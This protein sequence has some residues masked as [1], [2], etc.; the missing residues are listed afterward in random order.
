MVEILAPAGN[1]NNFIT[2]IDNGADAVYLGLKNFSARMGS[3]NFTIEELK[4]CI[5][6]AKLFGAKV[7][8]AVNTLI[9]DSELNDFISDIENAYLLGAD[10]FILQDIFLGKIIKEKNPDICLHL[11]TQAGVCNEYGA[12]LAK[13]FG[14]SRV[15]L[16]RETKIED[17]RKITKIIETEVFVQ[18][19]LCTSFSG[20]CYFSSIVGGCS[21]NR[22]M[23]KQPCRKLYQYNFG[24]RTESGYMLSLA[25]LCL[26][27]KI[28]LLIDAGV[29]SFKIEGRMRNEDYVGLATKFYKDLVNGEYNEEAFKYLNIAFNR[30]DYTEGLLISQD[31][32]LISK[33]IQS[34][35]G[36]IIGKVKKVYRDNELDVKCDNHYILPGDAFKILRDGYEVGNGVCIGS[37]GSCSY[38]GEARVGD[39]V[40]ITRTEHAISAYEPF[41]KK[42][43]DVKVYIK[44]GEKLR[45]EAEG[46]TIESD[47]IIEEAKSI[48]ISDDEVSKNFL[49]VDVYPFAVDIKVI[50]DNKSF[51]V[52]SELNRI[53]ASLYSEIFYRKYNRKFDNIECNINYSRNFDDIKGVITDNLNLDFSLFS[54]VIYSPLDYSKT[55][56]NQNINK[57]VWLYIPPYMTSKDLDL[58]RDKVNFFY[59]IYGDGY[60]T[61][62]YAMENNLKLFAGVG[63]NIFNSIDLQQLDLFNI[64]YRVLSKE[65]KGSELY[66]LDKSSP[67]LSSGSLELMDL[68]YCPKGKK[69]SECNNSNLFTLTDEYKRVFKVYRYKV[70]ECRFK[71][72]NCYDL[73]YDQSHNYI[74]DFRTLDK[75][76][77]DLLLNGKKINDGLDNSNF[78]K[79]NYIKGLK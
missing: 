32:K 34:N 21:G 4:Y 23:C 31:E 74:Y 50:N 30:G 12:K 45:A 71:L 18:G 63:F 67:V 59:G 79:G 3:E 72:F 17:I 70:S 1:K 62:E 60:W 69:C 61:L 6:Y 22:G 27:D 41:R 68:I 76:K 47:K 9:K 13:R 65:L 57:R 35:K 73:S 10:A 16:A 24:D 55:S 48:P 39:D 38:K 77:I 20:H 7:Y 14:F 8:I 28:D 56:V 2:A 49:R 25:D 29:S 26:K 43:I 54:D 11:S 44:C 36:Y 51:V 75:N 40:S 66:S 42:F 37:N 64:S 46:I 58:I 33:K 5:S 52:K 78:T 53:R 15:I 19:A